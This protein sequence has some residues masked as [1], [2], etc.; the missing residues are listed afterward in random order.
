MFISKSEEAL[1]RV[2]S[3]ARK[4]QLVLT[5]AHQTDAQLGERLG[6]AFQQSV[7]ITFKLGPQDALVAARNVY[8]RFD[9]SLVKHAPGD[10]RDWDVPRSAFLNVTEQQL[11]MANA[12]TDLKRQEVFI[13]V[14]PTVTKLRTLTVP[15]PR[16]SWTEVQAVEQHY[17]ERFGRP[18]QIVAAEVDGSPPGSPAPAPPASPPPSPTP[19]RPVTPR[20]EV[21]NDAED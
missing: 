15:E 3:L 8:T 17:A 7:H 2:L 18:R 1:A 14:G 5:V 19:P 9:P 20:I 10:P 12:L 21:I 11:A 4:Y 13:K 6:S 16:T